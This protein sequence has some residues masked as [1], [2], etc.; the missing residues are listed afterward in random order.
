MRINLNIITL[1]LFTFLLASIVLFELLLLALT[2]L[3][4]SAKKLSKVVVISIIW[5][6]F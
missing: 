4:Y 1:G 2:V 3:N 5:L 6:L